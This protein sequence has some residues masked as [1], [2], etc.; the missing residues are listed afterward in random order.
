[1]LEV[2]KK[3]VRWLFEITPRGPSTVRI[4]SDCRGTYGYEVFTLANLS[5]LNDMSAPLGH[6]SNVADVAG[7]GI[8]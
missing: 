5:F 4:T 6:P 2:S 8:T 3:L 1:V 7:R